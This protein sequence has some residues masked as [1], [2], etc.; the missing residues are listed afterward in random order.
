MKRTLLKKC[1][2]VL[3]MAAFLLTTLP[4]AAALATP[5]PGP[6]TQTKVAADKK[7]MAGGKEKP[8]DKDKAGDKDKPADKD[9]AG[10]KDKPADKDKAGDKEKPADKDKAGDKEKPADKDKPAADRAAYMSGYPDGTFR[11]GQKVSRAETAAAFSRLYLQDKPITQQLPVFS[12]ID[13]SGK[14]YENDVATVVNAKYMSGYPDGSFRPEAPITRAELAA[15]LTR[16]DKS[17]VKPAPF[18]DIKGHWAAEAIGRAHAKGWI[19]GY[20]DGNFRPD[21]PVTRAELCALFNRF[22]GRSLTADEAAKLAQQKGSVS[23]K[24]V[25]AAHWAYKDIL[26]AANAASAKSEQ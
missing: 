4:A 16:D 1:S 19:S 13:N 14:W 24:D 10:D 7:D 9:K 17:A 23:F 2:A 26:A 5:D 3:L 12:D 18:K 11:P 22:A 21:A 8:A 20:P 6:S 25:D 15:M